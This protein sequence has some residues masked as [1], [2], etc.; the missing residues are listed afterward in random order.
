MTTMPLTASLRITAL[1]L[2]LACCVAPA[3]HAA[4]TESPS[5]RVAL[6]ETLSDPA[7]ATRSRGDKYKGQIIDALTHTDPDFEA[8]R[9]PE[10]LTESNVVAAV[11]MP[12]PNEGLSNRANDGTA[13]KIR[14]A[15]D[16]RDQVKVFCGGDYL[17][18]WLADAQRFGNPDAGRLAKME[19][20]RSD[21]DSGL[22]LGV[23]E[24]GL[25]HFN[26]TGQQN[27]I[28]IQPDFAP[29]L[30]VVDM[31]GQ[32]GGWIQ[33]HVEPREP[34]GHTHYAELLTALALW[35]QRQPRL[36]IMLSHTGMT[37]AANARAI[38]EA[39]PQVWMSVKLM[40]TNN[41]HWTHLEPLLNSEG[42]LFEDW[43]QLFETMPERFV[44]GSDIKFGQKGHRGEGEYEQE[45]KRFRRMLGALNHE[46]AC[47]LGSR[48]A[49]RILAFKPLGP[50]ACP[51]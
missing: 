12:V 42:E 51:P 5:P 11:V 24:L 41:S 6:S 50:D 10:L 43:A 48:N 9:L 22:C 40:S 2:A 44:V 36:K 13:Q 15:Q 38:L 18:N 16:A 23:G 8:A 39:Y 31:V 17:S 20:L 45:I 7:R 30:Q 26:K 19:R 25:L 27:I 3:L 4:G 47:L 49:Q 34:N 37:S 35:T 1:G 14:L 46:T 33:L 21:L 28:Q 32:R 29:L